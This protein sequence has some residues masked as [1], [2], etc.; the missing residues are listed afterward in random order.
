[1]EVF[2]SGLNR[3]Q[4]N[5]VEGSW[6]LEML[7]RFHADRAFLGP[8]GLDSSAGPTTPSIAV[9]GTELAMARRTRGEVVVLEAAAPSVSA[10]DET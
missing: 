3:S 1:M 7:G 2:L 10:H 9:A 6:S 8:D 5:A 4:L